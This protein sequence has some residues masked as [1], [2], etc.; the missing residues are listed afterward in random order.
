LEGRYPAGWIVAFNRTELE[1][2]WGAW[3]SALLLGAMAATAIGLLLCW[4][5]LAAL[6]S[7][8]VRLLALYGDRELDWAACWRLSGAALM[9][10]AVLMIAALAIYGFG[11]MDLVALMFMFGMHWVVG[12]SYLIAGLM[13]ARSPGVVRRKNPF[14][15]AK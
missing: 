11:W 13:A 6:Y 12:W 5:M 2:L 7:P 3:R 8:L 14:T 9:P 1:P 15:P 4:W 10:G